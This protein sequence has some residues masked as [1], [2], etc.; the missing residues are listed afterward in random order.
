MASFWKQTK[1]TISLY[2]IRLITIP[3]KGQ[4]PFIIYLKKKRGEE[5]EVGGEG[6]NFGGFEG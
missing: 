5:R 3:I 2:I 1:S 6:L 4:K